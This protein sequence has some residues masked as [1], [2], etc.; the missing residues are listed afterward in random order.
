M[1]FKPIISPELRLMDPRI[2]QEA[3]PMGIKEE[4]LKNNNGGWSICGWVSDGPN[5]L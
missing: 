1:E 3:T 2:F 5:L 4:I